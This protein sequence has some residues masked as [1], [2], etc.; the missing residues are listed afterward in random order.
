MKTYRYGTWSPTWPEGEKDTVDNRIYVDL[1]GNPI[2]GIL[3]DF[4]SHGEK[5][6]KAH[7]YDTNSVIVRDGRY[8]AP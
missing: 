6:L 7:P 3:E 5:Y 4:K 8:R 1:E 2:T